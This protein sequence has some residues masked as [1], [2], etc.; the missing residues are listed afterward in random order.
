MR[1]LILILLLT[2]CTLPS[3]GSGPPTGKRGTG[4]EPRQT[5]AP[6]MAPQDQ[7]RAKG[8]GATMKRA[9]KVVKDGRTLA[10][11]LDATFVQMDKIWT[12]RHHSMIENAAEEAKLDVLRE[13]IGEDAYFDAL[14]DLMEQQECESCTYSSLTDAAQNNYACK[15][16]CKLKKRRFDGAT[17][18]SCWCG[19]KEYEDQDGCAHLDTARCIEDYG[20]PVVQLKRGMKFWRE[21]DCYAKHMP[22]EKP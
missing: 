13:D 18:S 4:M 6:K 10:Q 1:G 12:W 14:Y 22:E 8:V 3:P 2:G 16:R 15:I 19:G 9:T 11:K 17:P 21:D 5:T 7:S 20:V